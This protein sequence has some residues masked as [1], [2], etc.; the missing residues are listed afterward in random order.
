MLLLLVIPDPT[1]RVAPGGAEVRKVRCTL[2]GA[3]PCDTAQGDGA[4]LQDAL[5]QPAAVKQDTRGAFGDALWGERYNRLI[6]V[7]G[8]ILEGNVRLC[9]N[10]YL[11]DCPGSNS[12]AAT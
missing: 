6:E 5:C 12:Q 8:G 3:H 2:L 9:V 7:D 10:L 4:V 1:Q 11:R